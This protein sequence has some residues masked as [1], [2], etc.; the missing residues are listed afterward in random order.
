MNY[1]VFFYCRFCFFLMIRRPPRSTRTTH[2]FPT[3]R[4]S[5]LRLELF[6]VAAADCHAC[7]QSHRKEG[8]GLAHAA[9]TAGDEDSLSGQQIVAEHRLAAGEIVLGQTA[10]RSCRVV[11]VGSE[12]LWSRHAPGSFY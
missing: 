8:G 3:R 11:R 2:S 10:L 6:L 1:L 4:S 12:H 9:S 5:D 7:A